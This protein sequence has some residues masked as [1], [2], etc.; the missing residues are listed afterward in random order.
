M[1]SASYLVQG[2]NM[3]LFAL[4]EVTTFHPDGTDKYTEYGFVFPAYKG[5]GTISVRGLV[6]ILV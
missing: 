1:K 2:D 4:W 5:S 3:E 6:E